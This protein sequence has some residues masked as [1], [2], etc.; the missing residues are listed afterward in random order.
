M[1]NCQKE[2]LFG[3]RFRVKF[4]TNDPRSTYF[5]GRVLNL[6]PGAKLQ[7]P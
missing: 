2:S 4:R 3:T 6:N 1:E 7:V 5:S